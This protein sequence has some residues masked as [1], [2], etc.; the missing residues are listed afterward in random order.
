M[1][2]W[3]DQPL[4]DR[5]WLEQRFDAILA[6]DNEAEQLAQIDTILNWEDP[7]PGGFYDNLGT[8]GE[9]SHV[10]SQQSWEED[11]S[12]SH[13]TRVAFPNYKADAKTIAEQAGKAVA[14][15]LAFKEEVTRVA[16]AYKGRQELRGSWQSQIATL[17]GTPLK[18]R[19]E[20]LD[21]NA[22]YRL[23]VTYA[24]RFRPTM[25][26]TLNDEFGIHGP[27]P[28]PNPIWPVSYYLPQAATRSGTLN[29]EW[30]LVDGRGCMVAEVW[31]IKINAFDQ[32]RKE[33][34]SYHRSRLKRAVEIHEAKMNGRLKPLEAQELSFEEISA[35]IKKHRDALIEMNE[36]VYRPY[37]F[38]H[39]DY[40]AAE[41]LW[42]E[43]RFLE[44]NGGRYSTSVSSWSV[45]G[46]GNRGEY[47]I[48]L[49][50]RPDQVADWDEWF[51]QHD[52]P[53]VIKKMMATESSD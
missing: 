9:Y 40:P 3:L 39:V 41:G 46:R 53:G 43:Q 8:L 5:R 28:Q 47:A 31:L 21:P 25:T 48:H 50:C 7:G 1:L 52:G 45:S 37:R 2:D 49:W 33:Q 12:S 24:G 18:M 23:K 38:E 34:V 16:G 26:L 14:D 51:D 19:Y 29:V 30:N 20:G 27:V 22:Q 11:P 17:Y 10:V 4:N 32:L 44:R 35:R 42:L 6:L 36:L 13:S 15:E